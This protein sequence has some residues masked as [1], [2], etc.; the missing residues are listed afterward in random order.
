MFNQF[1]QEELP[2]AP[3]NVRTVNGGEWGDVENL[4]EETRVVVAGKK[5]DEDGGEW[6]WELR[7]E[8]TVG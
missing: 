1:V 8:E 5:R 6:W 3:V 4:A 2:L 7:E